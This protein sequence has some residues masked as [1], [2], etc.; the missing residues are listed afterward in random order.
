MRHMRALLKKS[1]S[2]FVSRG[3]IFLS[4]LLGGCV[5]EKS[6]SL[7][8]YLIKEVKASTVLLPTQIIQDQ[9]GTKTIRP[10]EWSSR[11]EQFSDGMP[12]EI[13]VKAG[14]SLTIL[15]RRYAVP[16]SFIIEKNKLQPPFLLSPGQKLILIGPKIHIVQQDENLYE[17]ATQHNVHVR[18]LVKK[19]NLP[20]EQFLQTGQ[21]LIL[22]VIKKAPLK[23]PEEPP[24]T[25]PYA[26]PSI[27]LRKEVPIR[28]GQKFAWPVKGQLISKFGSKGQ[29]LYNDGINLSA[30]EGKKVC[31]AENGIVVYRGSDIKSYGQLVLV[32]HQGGWMSAYAH[33]ADISVQKGQVLKKKDIL[34]SVG[35]SGFVKYPQ[36]H[37]ELRKNGKPKDPLEYLEAN[38]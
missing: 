3:G 21:H 17:I 33:L 26:D 32:K 16:I 30:S 23:E 19:N 35:Q 5:E 10:S 12:Q 9:R 24:K 27:L 25:E 6:P 34:G 11:T 20:S 1:T 4:F 22:P 8:P 29:G 38:A 13:K 28:S 14:D 36:L 15:S 31:V 7:P 37:F 2:N 18:D